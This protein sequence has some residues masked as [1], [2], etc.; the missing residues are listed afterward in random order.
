MLTFDLISM[1]KLKLLVN[2][3][4]LLLRKHIDDESIY[5][6]HKQKK[7]DHEQFQMYDEK[8]K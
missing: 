4:S 3:Y 8:K 1:D 2:R 7:M 5:F 6:R